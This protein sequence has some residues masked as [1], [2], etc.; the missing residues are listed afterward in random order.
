MLPN[1]G[2]SELLVIAFI[3]LLLFGAKR[4]PEIGTSLGKSIRGFKKGLKDLQNELPGASDEDYRDDR[5]RYNSENR[6]QQQQ[7]QGGQ[8]N[9]APR[10]DENN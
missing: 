5:P 7:Q 6:S 2:T 3:A 4:L 8:Q 9:S 10:K 1:I